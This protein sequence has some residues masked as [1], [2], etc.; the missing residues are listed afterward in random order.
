MGI[1]DEPSGEGGGEKR[2]AEN[3]TVGQHMAF[4][5]GQSPLDTIVPWTLQRGKNHAN[6]RYKRKKLKEPIESRAR[7]EPRRLSETKDIAVKS[8][9]HGGTVPEGEPLTA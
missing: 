2:N 6:A 3:E 4:N 7:R 8:S 1:N 9:D 5:Q